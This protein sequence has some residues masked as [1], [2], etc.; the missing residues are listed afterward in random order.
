[1]EQASQATRTRASRTAACPASFQ[2]HLRLQG[3]SQI[4]IRL[5]ARATTRS[6]AADRKDG[7]HRLRKRVVDV[8]VGIATAAIIATLRGLGVWP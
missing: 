8:A 6:I 5:Q 2:T 7:Q 3:P 4:T 1:M